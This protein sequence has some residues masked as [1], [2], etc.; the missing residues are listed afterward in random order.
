VD[1]S[2]AILV[3][4]D[5]EDS[6]DLLADLL[7]SHGYE[8]WLAENGRRAL[9]VLNQRGPPAL[10]LLDLTMPVMDGWQLHA[11]MKAIPRFERVPVIV[12]SAVDNPVVPKGTQGMLPKPIEIDLLFAFVRHYCGAPQVV[13]S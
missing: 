6:R 11:A 8:V 4:E 1:K 9:E 3:V 13:A 10:V 12:V 5:N 2:E 7:T